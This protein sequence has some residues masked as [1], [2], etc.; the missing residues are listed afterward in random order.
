[1]SSLQGALPSIT[2]LGTMHPSSLGNPSF[3][4]I[5]PSSSSYVS[6][7]PP[8]EQTLAPAVGPGIFILLPFPQS[9]ILC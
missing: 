8:Q 7:L 3:A 1:M 9:I 4:W 2:P 5:P 6:V